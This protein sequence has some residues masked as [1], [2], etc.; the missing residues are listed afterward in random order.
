MTPNNAT[1]DILVPTV[2]HHPDGLRT[3]HIHDP[4]SRVGIF[5]VCVH[6]G[7]ADEE[8]GEYGLAHFVEHT[9]FKGTDRRSSMD[10]LNRM[11]VVGGELNAYT[12]TETTVV[13]SI[14]PAQYADRAV[15]LIADLVMNSRFPHSEL[16]K[17]KQV[18]L[19]EINSYLDSPA[20]AIFDTFEDL[21][22]AGCGYGHNILGTPRSVR[23]F[24]SSDCRRF[25]YRYYRAPNMVAFYCGPEEAG[26]C[27]DL[28]DRHFAGL[29]CEPVT[30]P[31]PVLQCAAPFSRKRFLP[32]HQAHVVLGAVL[33]ASSLSQKYSAALLA[34]IAGGPGMNSLLNI[35]LRER[36]GLVYTVEASPTFMA[37]GN[38]L[39]TVY[40]GCDGDDRRECTDICTDVFRRLADGGLDAKA[41]EEARTQYLGQRTIA[42][43]NRENRT[44]AAARSTLFDGSPEPD[45]VVRDGIAALTPVDIAAVA[46]RFVTSSSSLFFLPKK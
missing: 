41:F 45:A 11:E 30:S 9:I 39:L 31:Q 12:T 26:Q 1:A 6:A 8:I 44:I 46:A 7:S 4:H 38:C 43:E 21:M 17:E 15:E 16:V 33:P 10:I 40:F 25:L 20:D 28:V 2:H 5:G 29:N 27:T 34:N 36:R 19:D 35:E 23:S 37:G 13:Y 42:V 14:F 24:K 18:V 32:V 22:F 3:V